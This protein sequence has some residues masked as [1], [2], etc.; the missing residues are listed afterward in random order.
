MPIRNRLFTFALLLFVLVL[1]GRTL[2][3]E[4]VQFL[5]LIDG[6]SMLVEYQGR[7]QMVRLIGVDAPE[8]GQEYGTNAKTHA[9]RFCYGK[10]LKLEFDKQRKDRYGRLLAYVYCGSDMLNE[11]LARAGLAL[12]GKY[13]PNTK[14]HNR[15][16]RAQKE[17]KA[18]GNGFWLYGGLKQTPAQWRKSH[19]R[20]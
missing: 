12:V 1:P 13:K 17:A 16:M 19:P 5:S 14:Y 6:D 4:T 9:L 8:R 20:K 10:T 11:E 7:S 15:L 18:R 3:A 2:A